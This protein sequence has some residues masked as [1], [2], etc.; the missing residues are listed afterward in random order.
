MRSPTNYRVRLKLL[1]SRLPRLVI[2][3]TNSRI[4]TQI[5]KTD[6][7]NQKET[8]KDITIVGAD[9]NE[10]K[11]FGWVFSGKNLPAAYLVGFLIGKKAKSKV[12]SEVIV[13]K[14]L[15]RL[16][17]N[18]FIFYVIKGAVDAGLPVRAG[19]MEI[20]E[21]RL[22]GE[23]IKE[24]AKNAKKWHFSKVKQNI[25]N[26]SNIMETVKNNIEKEYGR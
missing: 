17:K 24:M 2:R 16:H 26:I 3:K 1:K 13:D 20:D 10:L 25:E 21:K 19:E 5:I 9:G 12:D 8:V 6:L 4:I 15:Y 23:H 22:K 7:D 18:S 14:G 11:K